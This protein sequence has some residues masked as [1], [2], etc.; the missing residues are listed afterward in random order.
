MTIQNPST[1]P[2]QS[3][4]PRSDE[5]S[6]S[7][8]AAQSSE[9]ETDESAA[10]EETTSG[11]RVDISSAAQA[12]QAEVGGDAALIER[13]RKA[14]ETSSLS[15]DRLAELRERVDSGRYTE[16]DVAEQVAE[17]LAEDFGGTQAG[18]VE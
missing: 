10:A 2:L 12:A 7:Q 4:S 13:G 17:G 16:P 15:A 18:D 9:A 1:G 3:S 8:E 11:D 14:L 6:Q 5:T